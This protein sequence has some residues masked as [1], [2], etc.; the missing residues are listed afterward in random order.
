MFEENIEHNTYLGFG[1]VLLKSDPKDKSII[2]LEASNEDL[3]SDDEV[4]VMKA[5]E[6]RANQFL[7]SGVLSW[8]HL[9]KIKKDPEFIIGEPLDVKFNKSEHLTLV[10][11]R[12]YTKKNKHAQTVANMLEDE[13]TRLGAS[14]G[15]ALISKSKAYSDRLKR[16]V[17]IIADLKWDEVAVT[18]KP[19][20]KGTQGRCSFMPFPEFAKSFAFSDEKNIQKALEAGGGANASAFTGG[21]AL[22]GESLGKQ[23]ADKGFWSDIITGIYRKEI[24]D[25]RSLSSYLKKMGIKGKDDVMVIASI[26]ASNKHKLLEK[27][28]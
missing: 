12:L 17:P 14:I 23:I 25:Y 21:R 5:L 4:V 22:I 10:K 19:V 18:H 1:H 27:I 11:G 26:V 3:D 7:K 9:H 6:K 20:N 24:V 28:N 8:D 13:T 16:V 15:G 2:Y